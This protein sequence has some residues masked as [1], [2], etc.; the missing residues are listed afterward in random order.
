MGE[1][2]DYLFPTTDNNN[3]DSFSFTSSE[4]VAVDADQLL[5]QQEQQ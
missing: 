5:L 3:K 2:Q 4:R 1:S